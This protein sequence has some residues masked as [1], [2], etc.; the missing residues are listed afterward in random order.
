MRLDKTR[1]Y[2]ALRPHHL[3][4]DSTLRQGWTPQYSTGRSGATGFDET[5]RCGITQPDFAQRLSNGE[6]PEAAKRS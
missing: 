1:Q 2:F 3:L 4:L 5:V 6:E